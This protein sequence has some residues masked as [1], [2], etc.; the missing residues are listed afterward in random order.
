M[1]RK[2]DKQLSRILPNGLPNYPGLPNR[3]Y[4]YPYGL[5]VFLLAVPSCIFYMAYKAV[6]E[7][8]ENSIKVS[9]ISSA[10]LVILCVAFYYILRFNYRYW[11]TSVPNPHTFEEFVALAQFVKERGNNWQVILILE[12]ILNTF[13]NENVSAV[14]VDLG[15]AYLKSAGRKSLYDDAENVNI[16]KGIE[17]V[18]KGLDAKDDHVRQLAL[19]TLRDHYLLIAEQ[20]RSKEMN[21]LLRKLK[22][23]KVALG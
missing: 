4:L 7:Y 13:P 19:E 20:D 16:E 12:Y 14:E 15:I 3:W 23:D 21:D 17:Y 22:M 18:K 6:M 9:I 11:F 2:I 8:S 1:E 5:L 10:Y